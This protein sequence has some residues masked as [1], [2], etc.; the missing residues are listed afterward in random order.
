MRID[1]VDF[2]YLALPEVRDIG[3]GSQDA[4][5]VRVEAGGRVGWGECEAS[6]LVSIASW[7]CPMSHSACKPVNCS[8][9][10]QRVEGAADIRRINALVRKNSFDLLQADHTLSG[11]DIALWDLLG[12]TRGEPVWRLLGYERTYPKTVYASQL[13]GDDPQSTLRRGQ[14]V[15]RAGFR[16]AKFGWGPYG[17]GTA[18]E[19]ADHVQAAREGLGE[20]LT[21]LVDAGTAWGDDVALAA[22]RLPALEACR[23]AWLEEPFVNGALAAYHEL[24][25][26]CKT[27]KLAGGE[28][29][30]NVHQARAMM[31]YAGLGFVQIDTGRIGGITTAKQVADYALAR[32]I[33]FVNHTFTTHL[34]LSAS[35]QPCAGREGDDLCEYPFEPSA[36]ARDFTATKLVPDSRGQVHLPDQ[37]GLGLEP[38]WAALKKYVVEVE[39][40]VAGRKV[41]PGSS[42]PPAHK[43]PHAALRVDGGR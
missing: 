3:D 7:N 31:D 8:V 36:L 1:A 32:G 34:A 43:L 22:K 10:G 19:D 27:V 25:A 23:A 33:Q 15:A 14:K 18:K 28:G 30:H 24:A 2:F 5:L 9:L 35:L 13:F 6:P 26:R 39:I 21:L 41:F 38:D 16:A 42:Q 20:D 17:H 40:Q 29:C 11:I 4:L 37:P 12:K